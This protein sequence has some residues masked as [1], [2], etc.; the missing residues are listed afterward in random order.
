MSSQVDK[1]VDHFSV[2]LLP[3]NHVFK[4]GL[5]DPS[6]L[7][8]LKATHRGYAFLYYVKASVECLGLYAD[9]CVHTGLLLHKINN[10][11]VPLFE[12]LSRAPGKLSRVM[13]CFE[14]TANTIDVMALPGCFHYFL[15]GGFAKSYVE[16]DYLLIAVQAISTP[17]YALGI[18]QFGQQVGL[19]SL[20]S[21]ENVT[22]S[23]GNVRLLG[24]TS[25]AVP[26][27]QGH[28]P[29]LGSA[30]TSLSEHRFLGNS[31]GL[32][33]ILGTAVLS[34]YILLFK[35]AYDSYI[36]QNEQL[37]I[38]PKDERVNL[39]YER[40]RRVL[41]A[42]GSELLV[43]GATALG[44]THPLIK[45]SL[46]LFAIYCTARNFHFQQMNKIG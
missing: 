35:R 27:L 7:R 22:A 16:K 25:P 45:G 14:V 18:L 12:F 36:W 17:T 26:F 44:F 4:D 15:N 3:T 1:G 33:K 9:A 21:L 29:R 5:L 11:A 13:A 32:D 34:I 20:K 42:Y 8:E 46:G 23:F 43:R 24:W 2:V 37:K 30:V 19:Y 39:E 40:A 10:Y 6:N 28:F 41:W 31:S 38:A